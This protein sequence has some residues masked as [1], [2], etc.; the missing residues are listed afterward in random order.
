MIV[1]LVILLS[2][3]IIALQKIVIT[4]LKSLN[5]LLN[6][7][8]SGGGDL[9]SRI[10]VRS[11]DEFGELGNNFN[12][13]VG[14]VQEII[15][16]VAKASTQLENVTEQVRH[17][18]DQTVHST[19]VQSSLTDTSVEN[20]RQLDIA[21][22]EIADNTVSTVEQTNTA[23]QVSID[24]RKTIETN[25]SNISSLVDNLEKTANEVTSLK[26]ASDNIGSV[27]DVIKGIAEQTNLLALNAAIEA[28][29]AGESGRG[30]AVVADE[31]RALASKTH[32]STTEIESIIEELQTQAEASY[33]STQES[34]SRVADTISSAEE[35]STALNQITDQ[36]NSI[37]DMIHL[38]ASATEEQA[39]V[40]QTV[41]GDMVELSS[42]SKALIS[43]SN[44]LE[45]ATNNL[46]DVADQMAGQ[47]KRF[48]Y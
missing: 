9:T 23:Y 38:I 32:D 39:N 1:F 46:L 24:S 34:K 7:I 40:T 10:P 15:S 4:P 6:D 28:A 11:D 12:Q 43:G 42:S 26:Q 35:A 30:F 45:G 20:M 22:K 41:N 37:N 5:E 2:A 31:V 18:K 33:Q 3:T 36:M 27:L 25:I 14:T 47:I 29:R 21:T 16:D 44:E 17:I 19:E 8:A 13:F 48:K